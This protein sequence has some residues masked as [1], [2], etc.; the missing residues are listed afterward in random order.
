MSLTSFSAFPFE[1]FLMTLRK[2]VCTPNNPLCQ[3]AN[4]LKE[5]TLNTDIKIHQIISL[6]RDN[7]KFKSIN[8]GSNITKK[9]FTSVTWNEMKIQNISP[10]NVIQLKNDEIIQIDKIFSI[11]DDVSNEE[12][13]S[14]K[15]YVLYC[16]K[17]DVFKYPY[18]SSDVGLYQ[19][20]VSKYR[21]I[22]KVYEIKHKCV[23]LKI[24]NITY[25]IQLLHT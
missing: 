7:E 22:F 10:N 23:L 2:L 15:G 13:I 14:L 21:R 9:I 20:V 4:R 3:V 17:R 8:L 6:S 24:N 11:Q 1:N 16:D 12:N 18:K 19:V 25:C 5:I